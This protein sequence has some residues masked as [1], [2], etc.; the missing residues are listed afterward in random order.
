MKDLDQMA[1]KLQRHNFD[2]QVV[3]NA[4][5][6]IKAVLSLIPDDASVGFGGSATVRDLGL[7]ETLKEMG[8]DVFWHW[9]VESKDMGTMR[10]M[11]ASA[12]YYLLSA[13]ALTEEGEIINTDGAGNRVA[14]MF[15][16]P[17]NVIFVIG[18]N[19]LVADYEA[20]INRI[21][22]VASPL[23]AKRLNLSTPCAILG[24]CTDCSHPQRM[25]HITGVL[26]RPTS[27]VKMHVLLVNEDLG[28]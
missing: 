20:A 13:N 6:A 4:Q 12:D 18:K 15:Y 24:Y 27:G 22:N 11:A 2:A 17:K 3:D 28:F 21:R 10:K 23:N 26:H 8:H 25:C 5:E 19:K 16:G 7:Y 9:M 14:S 1:E